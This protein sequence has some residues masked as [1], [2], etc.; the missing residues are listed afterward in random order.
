MAN[1]KKMPHDD[2]AGSCLATPQ[3]DCVSA[4]AAFR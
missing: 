3:I 2:M 4:V 1:Q